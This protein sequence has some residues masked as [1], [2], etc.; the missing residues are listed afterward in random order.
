MICATCHDAD[1]R[2]GQRN[3]PACHRRS[4]AEA[5]STPTG[6][7]RLD[8]RI[9]IPATSP[10]AETLPDDLTAIVEGIGSGGGYAML[11]ST[12]TGERRRI[13]VRRGRRSKL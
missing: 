2:P 12:T 10:T 9:I 11:T 4:V 8:L 6:T 3:C 5:R 13:V 1:A 7:V